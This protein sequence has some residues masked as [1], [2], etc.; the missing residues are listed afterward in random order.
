MTPFLDR[1]SF[2][3]RETDLALAEVLPSPTGPEARVVEAARYS[4]MGEGKRLR[5]VLLLATGD[6]FG[7]PHS[8]TIPY[9]CAL[10]MIHTYSL[11][12]DDLPC[13]DDDDLRRGRPTCHR[14]YDEA[15]AVLAGD[16]LL[17]QA[18]ELLFAHCTLP[19]GSYGWQA[20]VRAAFRIARM[21]GIEGMIGGQATDMH[22]AQNSADEVSL[23]RMHRMKTGALLES[24][25]LVPADLA[26]PD[27]VLVAALER[28]A[29]QAG[30]AFQIRDDLLDATATADQL[31]KTPGKDARDHKS[32]YV[33]LLGLDEA[34]NRMREAADRAAV[35]LGTLREADLDTAFLDGLIDYL[36]ERES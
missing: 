25:L 36:T 10:E 20:R 26:E 6:M 23:R 1:F 7:L 30:L 28:Y 15:T 13:M 19:D 16:F 8:E 29:E 9:A 33:S 24:A 35:S 11:I 31:G 5:P 12:H 21:A 4:L 27:P 17:N 14:Q 32:T 34:Q 2:L 22:Y 3:K 18:F